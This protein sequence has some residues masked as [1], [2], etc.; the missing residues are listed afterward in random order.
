MAPTID[1]ANNAIAINVFTFGFSF[2]W[3]M[4][5]THQEHKK[6]A[7][8]HQAAESSVEIFSFGRSLSRTSTL[9][10][11][12]T[13]PSPTTGC[14]IRFT[15]SFD[16]SSPLRPPLALCQAGAIRIN[17]KSGG[18]I[19]SATIASIDFK[20]EVLRD[21]ESVE[22]P[23][24]LSDWEKVAPFIE[25]IVGLA[26]GSITGKY[27]PRQAHEGLSKLAGAWV[28]T[29]KVDSLLDRVAALFAGLK[30][31]D[32]Y[33]DILQFWMEFFQ[34]PLPGGSD[35]DNFNAFKE[36]LLSSLSRDKAEDLSTPH[37]ATFRERWKTLQ[38]LL[39]H[40]DDLAALVSSAGS[41]AS[42]PMPEGAGT[43]ALHQA[44]AKLRPLIQE[45][46]DLVINPDRTH[47]EL[48]PVLESVW[49]EHDGLFLHELEELRAAAQL[50]A[51][52]TG[53]RNSKCF[54]GAG[55]L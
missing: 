18:C 37:L 21:F 45:A 8:L 14:R 17:R 49:T 13:L 38:A 54:E 4:F 19:D 16:T 53:V 34:N 9:A 50:V 52:R 1:A 42:T 32:P 29:S 15:E 39:L 33:D 30:Q 36:A 12:G 48:T 20:P 7:D 22:L 55:S 24:A 47:A 23:K 43:K 25:V 28:E 35:E 5:W 3:L 46:K 31:K 44:V 40:F 10:D 41:Y 27:E 2:F 51:R 6:T 11:Q 26:P